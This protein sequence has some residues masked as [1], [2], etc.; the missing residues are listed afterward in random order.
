MDRRYA[1]LKC[2]YNTKGSPYNEPICDICLYLREHTVTRYPQLKSVT[3]LLCMIH[4]KSEVTT[5]Q[6]RRKDITEIKIQ[7][8]IDMDS[9]YFLGDA[10]PYCITNR[11]D[12]SVG[13]RACYIYCLHF[14]VFTYV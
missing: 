14:Y 6:A 13:E 4:Y 1:K 5:L 7:G 3:H 8:K 10:C 12:H 11:H 9:D 2:R